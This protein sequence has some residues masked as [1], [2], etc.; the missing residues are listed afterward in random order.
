MSLK[1]PSTIQ[2]QLRFFHSMPG[3]GGIAKINDVTVQN[4]TQNEKHK[5]ATG[6]H[7]IVDDQDQEQTLFGI[8]SVPRETRLTSNAREKGWQKV[9]KLTVI[10]DTL[11]VRCDWWLPECDLTIYA[12]RIEFEGDGRIDTS[13]PGWATPKAQDSVGKT[14]GASGANGHAGGDASI[15]A[16]EIVTPKGTSRKRII[17]DG[18]DGQ[19]GGK[20][21]NGADGKNASGYLYLSNGYVDRRSYTDSGMKTTVA[22]KL[23]KHG[24]R[25][26]LGIR[27]IW[28][29]AEFFEGS[30]NVEGTTV[31]PTNGEPS[32]APGDSGNGGA[33][34]KLVTNQPAIAKLWSGKP[35]KA[36]PRA[37]KATGGRGGQPRASVFYD[38]TY[39]HEFHLW[40][41]DDNSKSAKVSFTEYSTKDGSDAEGKAG[42]D[43]AP[44]AEQVVETDAAIW[45][46]PTLVPLTMGYIRESY[47]TEQRDEAKRLVDLYADAFLSPL[48]TAN[49]AW[50]AKDGAYWRSIQ[51]ELATLAQRLASRLDYFGKPAGY[52]PLLSLSSSF[53]LYRME[54]DMALEVLMFTSWVVEKQRSQAEGAESSEAAARLILKENAKLVEQIG[55]AE[56]KSAGLTQ[57]IAAL[58]KAQD[59]IQG[60]L[61]VTYTRLYNEASNDMAKKGQVKF[62]ANLAA[63]LCQV[64]PVGQP[65]LGGV[66]SMAADATDLLD[67]DPK[68]VMAS[69]K[70]RL[71]DTVDA[72]KAAKKDADEVIK[73]AKDEAKE[74]AGA[75]G[76]KKLSVADIKKLSETKPSAWSTVGKGLA[77]AASH[78][79]KA[80][81]SMQ[82][83]QAEIEAQLAK[84]AAKDEAWKALSKEIKEVIEQRASVQEEVIQLG[85]QVG[86]GYADLA[87]N[88]DSLAGLFDKEASARTRLLNANAFTAIEGMRNR[89][90]IALTE[91][92]YNLVRAFE[93][94][95]LKSV[96]V[97]WSLDTL[98]EQVNTLLSDKPLHKW[99][100]KEVR[101]RVATLKPLFKSNL[102]DIRASLIKDVEKLDMVDRDVDLVIDGDT[103]GDPIELLN[104]GVSAEIST[105][106]LGAV[107]PDWQRQMMAD[108]RLNRI[109]FEGAPAD[110]PDKGDVEIIIEIGELG[111]VRNDD[112]LYGLRLPV[113][114]VK[115]YRYHFSNG[116]ITKAQQSALAKDLMNLILDDADDRIKQKM[117]MPSAWTTLTLKA[118]FNL[119]GNKPAPKI[120]RIDLTMVVSSVK[121]KSKQIVLDLAASDGF[122]ALALP[123]LSADG[124]T[125]TYRIFDGKQG[126][127]EIRVAEAGAGTVLDHWLVSQ[128]GK[129][130]EKTGQS[131]SLPIDRNTRVE[132]VF[133]PA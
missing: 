9:A 118:A 43:A 32:I 120:R 123:A 12:R 24:D 79:K 104:E 119:R 54:V 89:A 100:D 30:N 1:P 64:V 8:T 103:G 21:Q 59:G 36:G 88:M 132:A 125:E 28:K 46:H 121:A 75:E 25:Q 113:S 40:G 27:R 37:P 77:P 26:V 107:E 94:S 38:C 128:G 85:Q 91:A 93:S 62:A 53:Q 47:L 133:R 4:S 78:L 82:L 19:G 115:S 31:P 69:L 127:T 124:F 63:A 17:T 74:L 131:I 90:R 45:L 95:L 71:G 61:D 18:L 97:N 20:G 101:D 126:D 99:T 106:R 105:L 73:K 51:T 33:A 129:T 70:T 87:D 98:Y 2:D 72:Y 111:I 92:L 55:G 86:Q 58:A 3:S 49:K 108:I 56:A 57:R 15:Y 114:L 34:G 50:K 96:E 22:V 41:D 122:S 109:V 81:E 16:N 6:L 102:A 14:P 116:T 117:A 67:K 35:G 83:P 60:K 68:D 65:I 66:A 13:P 7:V 130:V 76:G 112:Q 48:P 80:Y 10:C 39:Y 11:T 23:D 44:I 84:L 110:L 42:T 52:T 29:V 5:T